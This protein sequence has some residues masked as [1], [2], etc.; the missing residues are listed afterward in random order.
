MTA[1]V[2]TSCFRIAAITT[3]FYIEPLLSEKFPAGNLTQRAIVSR[4]SACGSNSHS[5]IVPDTRPNCCLVVGPIGLCVTERPPCQPGVRAAGQAALKII[6][7]HR[8]NGKF[9]FVSKGLTV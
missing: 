6:I 2:V 1:L 5:T 7:I 4:N 3:E 8:L 9:P